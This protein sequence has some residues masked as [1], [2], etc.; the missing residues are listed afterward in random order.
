MKKA[1]VLDANILFRAILG[2]KIAEQLNHYKTRIDFFTPAFCYEELRKHV[3]KIAE[4]KN[5]PAGPFNEAIGKLEKVVLPL[6]EEIYAHKEREAKDRIGE[7]D[8]HDWPIV[9]L[10]LALN[11]PVWTEDRD[12]FGTGLS[13]WSSRNIEI[14][15]S[16]ND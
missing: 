6:D 10:A 3:P 7:R 11:C 2:A 14:Y 4:A 9:A 15:L 12:F 13:V 5:L 1:V 8:I 16:D